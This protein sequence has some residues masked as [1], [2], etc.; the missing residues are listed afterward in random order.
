[1]VP[2]VRGGTYATLTLDDGDVSAYGAADVVLWWYDACY[3]TAPSAYRRGELMRDRDV[4]SAVLGRLAALHADDL[5]TKIVEELGVWSGT[6]RIDIAVINGELTGFELKS[7]KDTLERLPLQSDIYS[8]VFDRVTL[9][10]SKR[11]IY[12]AR[13]LIPKWWGLTLAQLTDGTISLTEIRTAKKN[14]RREPYLIAEMLSKDEAIV[15]LDR[16]GL[17]TGWRSKR[18]REIH[19]RLASELPLDILAEAVRMTMK[20]RQKVTR[21]SPAEFALGDD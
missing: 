10:T 2:I 16:F 9:V 4:R 17:A 1:M 14:P 18:V 8:R 5:D 20:L 12:K 11:H 7:E 21:A 15:L 13:L 3:N 6:V 19:E